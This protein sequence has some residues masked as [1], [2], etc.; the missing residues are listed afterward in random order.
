MD[1]G[2]LSNFLY[3]KKLRTQRFG[4]YICFRPQ[5][6]LETLILLGPL[7]RANL[8]K[9]DNSKQSN[10]SYANT[11]DQPSSKRVNKKYEIKIVINHSQTWN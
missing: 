2:A 6:R 10:Y 11:W 9:L 5:V 8:K 1:V 7:E 3:S 4:N